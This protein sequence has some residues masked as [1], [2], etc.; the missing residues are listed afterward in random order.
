MRCCGHEYEYHCAVFS[1]SLSLSLTAP[2]CPFVL[3]VVRRWTA[4]VHGECPRTVSNMEYPHGTVWDTPSRHGHQPIKQS[5]W[6]SEVRVTR[7]SCLVLS[8]GKKKDAI[9]P[10]LHTMLF[11]SFHFVIDTVVLPMS[12]KAH[13]PLQRRVGKSKSKMSFY[14]ADVDADAAVCT[15]AGLCSAPSRPA[16]GAR[17]EWMAGEWATW[18]VGLLSASW[19]SVVRLAWS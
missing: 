15:V 11:I 3:F 19:R 6:I 7:L 1:L 10:K 13:F 2:H 9:H 8:Q 16:G 5:E 12:C 4:R 14:S 17:P 18:A